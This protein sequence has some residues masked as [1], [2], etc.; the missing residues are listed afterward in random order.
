MH[1]TV[2]FL[3]FMICQNLPWIQLIL[4]LLLSLKSP[5]LSSPFQGSN[6]ELVGHEHSEESMAFNDFY[7]ISSPNFKEMIELYFKSMHSMT[8]EEIVLIQ[9]LTVCQSSNEKWLKYRMYRLT[10]SNVYSPAVNRVEPSSKLNSL[11][12]FRFSSLSVENE[13]YHEP[14]VRNLYFQAMNERGFKDI[15]GNDV[16]L[17]I[18]S[19][20]SFL[21]ASLDGIV[22]CNLDTWGLEIK[23]PYSK[24]NSTLSSALTDKKF[25]LKKNDTI[26]LL[27]SHP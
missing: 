4:S 12:Y 16:G 3:L 27:R 10:A 26:E 19:K 14:H 9:H 8:K 2:A 13:R 11:F 22:Q 5:S 21:G 18:S 23:C 25:F 1:P 15:I 7:D 17:L 6:V 24:Y 20:N